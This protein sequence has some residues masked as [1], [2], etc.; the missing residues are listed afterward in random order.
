MVLYELLN[1]FD[2]ADDVGATDFTTSNAATNNSCR[3]ANDWIILN[4][5]KSICDRVSFPVYVE[6][7]L[8]SNDS[9]FSDW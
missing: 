1:T 3:S 2:T 7:V 9:Y 8:T 6:S 4:A 5:A